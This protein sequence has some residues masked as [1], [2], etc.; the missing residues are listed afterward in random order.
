MQ[1]DNART[2]AAGRLGLPQN[3]VV[4]L[5]SW[6]LPQHVIERRMLGDA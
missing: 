1:Q 6:R 5:D 3:V 2:G 4:G